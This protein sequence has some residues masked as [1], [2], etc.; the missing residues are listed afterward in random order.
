MV[1]TAKIT[2][3]IERTFSLSETA[4]AMGHVGEGHTRGKVAITV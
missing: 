2:P 4:E 1:E 3:V